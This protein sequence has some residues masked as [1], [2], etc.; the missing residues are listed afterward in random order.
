[1]VNIGTRVATVNLAFFT[2]RNA[3]LIERKMLH[4][5]TLPKKLHQCTS[6]ERKFLVSTLS[7]VLSRLSKPCVNQKQH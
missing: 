4:Y 2:S 3:A 1:M 7:D 6:S 5:A